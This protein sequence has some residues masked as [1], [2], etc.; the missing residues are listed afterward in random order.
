MGD[1]TSP[2]TE[3]FFFSV[4]FREVYAFGKE[5][6]Y[7]KEE[8]RKKR[9]ENRGGRRERRGENNVVAIKHQNVNSE[10]A[11]FD[12]TAYRPYPNYTRE[13]ASWQ[14]L[15]SVKNAQSKY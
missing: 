14:C 2:I 7:P 10:R 9:G 4:R 3:L 15:C 11:T 1:Q 8:A 13:A 6:T 12:A 5:I